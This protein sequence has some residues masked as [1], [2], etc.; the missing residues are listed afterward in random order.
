MPFYL[1]ECSDCN[2]NEEI[3]CAISE[4]PREG[5]GTYPKCSKCG[6]E[7]NRDYGSTHIGGNKE[8][9]TPLASDS[10]AMNPDQIP[11]H[12][13]MFPDVKVLPDGRPVFEN[14]KQHDKYLK[15]TGFRKIPKKI[16]PKGI[17][18]A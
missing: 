8:Y 18:I 9:G 16:K 14:F 4:R 2:T 3:F 10:L 13:R 1:F 11:E 12:N 6:E 15:A 7:M 17:R 5:T